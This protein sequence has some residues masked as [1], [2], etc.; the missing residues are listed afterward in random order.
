M[1]AAAR[2]DTD[3]MRLAPRHTQQ[4]YTGRILAVVTLVAWLLLMAILVGGAA[5]G[6]G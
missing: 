3:R 6:S 2:A 4:L 5:G 1:F